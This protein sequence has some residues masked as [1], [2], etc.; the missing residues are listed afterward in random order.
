MLGDLY[1]LYHYY[2][3]NGQ[4]YIFFFIIIITMITI[5]TCEEF[6]HNINSQKYNFTC[7]F[8]WA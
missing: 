1:L 8:V 7:C 3:Y 2:Y 4:N 5:T 6:M